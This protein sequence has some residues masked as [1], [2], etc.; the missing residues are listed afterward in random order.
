MSRLAT[1]YAP[2][3]FSLWCDSYLSD[4]DY[5]NRKPERKSIVTINRRLLITVR[6]SSCRCGCGFVLENFHRNSCHHTRSVHDVSMSR[7]RD[8]QTLN[9]NYGVIRNSLLSSAITPWA[10]RRQSG[11][12]LHTLQ[13]GPFLRIE[14][15]SIE[16]IPQTF[17][18]NTIHFIYGP[19]V[20]T[21][22]NRQD[23]AGQGKVPS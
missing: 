14:Q 13:I 7:C 12:H 23:R 6:G 17:V 15:Q 18:R 4:R 5:D 9:L 10:N 22:S 19:V 20:L 2:C 11:A 1:A 3:L 8:P 16:E 21:S